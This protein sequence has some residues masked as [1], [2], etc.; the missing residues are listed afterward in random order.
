MIQNTKIFEGL[1][2][3]FGDKQV[4]CQDVL[5]P[6]R[7]ELERFMMS[8]QKSRGQ[9]VMSLASDY[10]MPTVLWEKGETNFRRLEQII[11]ERIQHLDPR[12][13]NLKCHMTYKDS[14]IVMSLS[15]DVTP[16]W[17]REPIEFSMDIPV[18]VGH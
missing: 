16:P 11:I 18:A 6:I 12:C 1:F 14:E 10:G 13:H 8:R 15:L 5:T 3:K 4:V 7:R 2:D 17:Q 9:N